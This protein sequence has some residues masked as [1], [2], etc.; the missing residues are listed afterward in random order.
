MKGR[1]TNYS[2]YKHKSVI[3]SRNTNASFT[4]RLDFQHDGNCHI[5]LNGSWGD[6][7]IVS[8]SIDA[9]FERLQMKMD[10]QT[11]G[12][13]RHSLEKM[14]Q[15]FPWVMMDPFSLDLQGNMSS[16]MKQW[17]MIR[18]EVHHKQYGTVNQRTDIDVQVSFKLH[19]VDEHEFVYTVTRH[20]TLSQCGL[21]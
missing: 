17:E 5:D 15:F 7:S 10:R 21:Y 8:G 1:V 9:R 11:T 20:A 12:E 4:N 18:F 14:F 3:K 13:A 2:L 6:D 19:L 16:S